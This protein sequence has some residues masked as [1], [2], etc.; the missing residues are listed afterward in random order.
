MPT[1][2]GIDLTSSQLAELR[3]LVDAYPDGPEAVKRVAGS[4]LGNP[5][6]GWNRDSV[7]AYIALKENRLVSGT[8]ADNGFLF[9]GLE[10][11]GRDFVHDLAAKE[12]FEKRLR[13]QDRRSAI[14]AA[15]VG[16]VAGAAASGLL[17][18]L[19]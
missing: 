11:A 14:I 2:N 7:S 12:D 4:R 10:L 8:A 13:R 5:E 19:F 16:A 6:D 1:C 3:L 18:P 15:V 9:A 17:S